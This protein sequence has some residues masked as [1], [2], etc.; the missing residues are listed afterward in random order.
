MNGSSH[1]NPTDCN[2]YCSHSC[3][4]CY[5]NYR[6][7]CSH[8]PFP[9]PPQVYHHGAYPPRYG[10]YPPSV[11]PPHYSA[12]QNPYDYDYV[13]PHCYGCPNHTSNGGDND[14]VKIEEQDSAKDH[15]NEFSS[16]IQLPNYPYPVAWTPSSYPKDK[17]S[18]EF[19]V[20]S[21]FMDI[22]AADVGKQHGDE[23]KKEDNQ[24]R[25]DMDEKHKNKEDNSLGIPKKWENG[26]KKP[27]DSKQLSHIK[28]SKLPPICL[29]VDP[30]P[31]K[32][33]VNGT[34]RSPSPS[35]LKVKMTTT[36]NEETA[37]V[38]NDQLSNKG[39]GLELIPKLED[40]QVLELQNPDLVEKTVGDTDDLRIV[41]EVPRFEHAVPDTGCH[42]QWKC[43]MPNG[44]L[45]KASSRAILTAWVHSFQFQ[46]TTKVIRRE[47]LSLTERIES[48]QCCCLMPSVLLNMKTFQA[49]SDVEGKDGLA[50]TDLRLL[51]DAANIKKDECISTAETFKTNVNEVD[52]SASDQEE[53][54]L[55]PHE[56]MS[57]GRPD[58]L[59]PEEMPQAV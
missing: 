26:A 23:N 17:D 48:V 8:I 19:R 10:S 54:G 31:R 21:C 7:P 51:P 2:G 20:V 38:M 15:D 16:L 37:K 45:R 46:V 24:K 12:N 13:K 50:G 55:A 39:A 36:L 14:N 18:E 4:L 56:N 35:G 25:V 42:R 27:S 6:P 28:A 57:F 1:P 47:H 9:P 29:R 11:I 43:S 34:S 44:Q 49:N 40:L 5:Y 3:R 58:S 41:T 53:D 22:N 59:A 52:G 32:K 30:L 33:T